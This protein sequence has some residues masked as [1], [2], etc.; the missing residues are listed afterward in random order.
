MA[1]KTQPTSDI[2]L[3]DI[4]TLNAFCRRY[5]DLT[6]EARMRWAIFNRQSNGLAKSGAIVKRQGRW[7][8]V[9]PRMKDWILTGD[10][11][12]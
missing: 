4:Q 9:V 1:A 12:A 3:D 8:V 6:D 10:A 2:E 7:Y 11:S 5:T